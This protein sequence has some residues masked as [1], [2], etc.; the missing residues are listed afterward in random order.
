MNLLSETH[1]K[2]HC[3]PGLRLHVGV[4]LAIAGSRWIVLII[5]R[6]I[7]VLQLYKEVDY[8]E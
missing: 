8:E 2:E 3:V 5:W 6:Y 1:A 7:G 4:L